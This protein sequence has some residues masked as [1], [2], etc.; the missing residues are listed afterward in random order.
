MDMFTILAVGLVSAGLIA[1]LIIRHFERRNA[2][3]D[4]R[5]NAASAGEWSRI[6]STSASTMQTDPDEAQDGNLNSVGSARLL[7]VPD[8]DM[9][10]I[11]TGSH[12]TG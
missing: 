4:A 8:A 5:M 7:S 6:L 9:R 12:W 2:K 1:L 10:D 11:T 3:I